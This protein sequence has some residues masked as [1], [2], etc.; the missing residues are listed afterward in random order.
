M[1]DLDELRAKA[2]T[3]YNVL[4][5]DRPI[6]FGL[7]E[8]VENGQPESLYIASIHGEGADPILE[9]AEQ[10][11]FS[12]GAGAYLF[13]GNRGTG[14]TTELMR[15]AKQLDAQGC[16]VFYVDMS[17][18]L[19]LTQ[20]IEVTDFLIAVLG[21][22]SE[23]V[24][25]RFGEETGKAGF[26]ERAWSFLNS[27]VGFDA[28]SLPA[29]PL[30][31]KAALRYTPSFNEELQNRTRSKVQVLVKQARDF[32]FE[33]VELVRAAR[34]DANKK[35]V[36]IVDSVERL[37]G[38]G[39]PEQIHA[40]FQ[41]AVQLFS[42]DAEQLRFGGL[43]VVYTIPPYLQALVG[44]L[45][46]LYSGG[47]IYALPSVHVYE[48]CPAPG[49]A[50]VAS[51]TGLAKLTDIVRRRY[52]QCGEF[53]SDAQMRRLAQSSGGDLRDF[54]RM[55]RL[56]IT[57]LPRMGLSAVEQ[58]IV[59]AENAVRSD[60]LPIAEDDRAWLRQI[61]HEHA[62]IL[63][64]LDKLPDFAR[65]QAGSYVLSYRNGE[66]WYAVHPLLRKELGLG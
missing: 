17:E 7:T 47:R 51:E 34:G 53:F 6:D 41:S 55:L 59:S 38:V 20:R 66:D 32:A 64:S 60:M 42:A 31:L 12:L 27:D 13:T 11:D 35:V 10:I 8:L 4:D 9:L 21:G 19:T 30:E 37:R 62:P 54:F 36:L 33:V 39:T 65:L 56:A 15:L 49:E 28:L 58:V 43:S 45:G 57:N 5:F 14:K 23:K 46:K 1:S 25:A 40:V 26:F 18:Y 44:G 29:G 52:S 16:E 48:C 63:P 61:E 3:F 50:P 22:L 2:K 24:N